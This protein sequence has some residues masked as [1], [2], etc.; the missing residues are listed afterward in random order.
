MLAEAVKTS[1]ASAARVLGEDSVISK[2]A[3]MDKVHG[4]QTELPF[5][6]PEKKKSVEHLYIEADEDHIH[7]QE[8]NGT[9]KKGSM[10]GK[11]LYLYER[12]QEYIDTNYESRYLNA[13][14]ISGDGGAWIKAGAEYIEKGVPVLDKFHMMKYINKAANQMLDEAGEAKGRL[15][16]ALYKGKKKKFVKTIKAIRKCAPNEKAVNDC[17]EYLLNNWDSAVRR[18]QDK[19][20]YGCSAEGHVSHMYSDRMSSRPM[21]WSEAGADAMC[22]LRC[23]VKDYGEEK[24]LELVKYRRSHKQEEATGTEEI[25]VRPNRGYMRSLLL[26][27]HDNDRVYIEKLQA[28]IP[29]IDIRKKLAIRERLGGI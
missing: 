1:Y 7:K 23:Y 24:I 17:E 6:K 10:I 19:N 11:L 27:S 16:K 14:Y 13:V 26:H 20:V 8:K 21:G 18:M 9:E 25:S 3:V 5:L 28:T 4:I 2:T 22:Q 29:S 12:M 15:W